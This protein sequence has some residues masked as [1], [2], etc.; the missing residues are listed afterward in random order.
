MIF[1]MGK[2]GKDADRMDEIR[3]VSLRPS[4]GVV[5]AFS[6]GCWFGED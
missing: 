1:T 5:S 4:D 3:V 2:L 6:R